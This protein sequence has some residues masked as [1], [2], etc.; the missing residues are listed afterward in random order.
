MTDDVRKPDTALDIEI[1]GLLGDLEATPQPRRAFHVR[2]LREVA[3]APTQDVLRA[4]ALISQQLRAADAARTAKEHEVGFEGRKHKPAAADPD[5]P[6][7]AN[8]TIRP[9]PRAEPAQRR[10]LHED[11]FTSIVAMADEQGGNGDA[12][13]RMILEAAIATAVSRLGPQFTADLLG[14]MQI[15]LDHRP[16]I[17]H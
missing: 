17:P 13:A 1:S 6:N 10:R 4:A 16:F 3:Q 9:L 11:L 12:E 5:G 7:W 15:I 14:E 8:G 2:A